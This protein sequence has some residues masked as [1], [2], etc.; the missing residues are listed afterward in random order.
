MKK[1]I[2]LFRGSDS[3]SGFDKNSLTGSTLIVL[4]VIGIVLSAGLGLK[5]LVNSEK[6]QLASLRAEQKEIELKVQ[7]LQ[8]KFTNLKVS[9]DLKAEQDRI[10]NQILSRRTLMSLLDQ[11]DAKQTVS[12]SSYMQALADASL[13]NSWL[14]NFSLDIEKQA[15]NLAGEATAGPNVSEMLVEIGKTKPFSGIAISSL[16]VKST[17]RGVQFQALAELRDNE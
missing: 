11:I 16:D 6:E 14:T 10:R 13:A 8:S 4:A 5:L 15:F 3:K 17:D 2:N 12:F 1:R 9:T 7:D